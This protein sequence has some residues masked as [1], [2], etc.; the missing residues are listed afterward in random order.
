[1]ANR[2]YRK[3]AVLN[4]GGFNDNLHVMENLDILWKLEK[5]GY[6]QGSG[7]GIV[8]FHHR[9][10]DRFKTRFIL[11]NAFTYGYHWHKLRHLHPDKVGLSAMPLKIAAFAILALISF[12]YPPTLWILIASML[13]WFAFRFYRDGRVKNCII[14][15]ESKV[16]KIGAI[17]FGFFLH[18]LFEIAEE[19]GKL[20]S[21]IS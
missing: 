16:E 8:F 3:D 20:Y 13:F 5:A 1:M 6:K 4:V 18:V 12:F 7:K 10:A 15:M 9:P 19:L 21:M 17:I 11:E 14:H 2:Y